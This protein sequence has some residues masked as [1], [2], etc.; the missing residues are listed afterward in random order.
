MEPQRA[1][2]RK[3]MK[4]GKKGRTKRKKDEKLKK[5]QWYS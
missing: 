3:K 1:S 4:G 2:W 5:A